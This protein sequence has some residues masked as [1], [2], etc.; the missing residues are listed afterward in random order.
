MMLQIMFSRECGDHQ[1][2][3]ALIAD[4]GESDDRVIHGKGQVFFK[5]EGDNL[6]QLA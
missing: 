1:R 5:G 3:A 4:A 6:M 2:M